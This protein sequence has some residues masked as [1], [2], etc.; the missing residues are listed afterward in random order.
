[1]FEALR[2]T[3]SVAPA[4]A[5]YVEG[6]IGTYEEAIKSKGECKRKSKRQKYI[7]NSRM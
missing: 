7:R 6:A 4:I 1:M 3:M 2:F 5:A